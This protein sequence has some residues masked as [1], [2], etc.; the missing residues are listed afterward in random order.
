MP[1][2]FSSLACTTTSTGIAA[3]GMGTGAEEGTAAVDKAAAST[4]LYAA[5]GMGGGGGEAGGVVKKKAYSKKLDF[6]VPSSEKASRVW[7][8]LDTESQ[9]VARTEPKAAPP[10]SP[11]VGGGGKDS[12]FFVT[13]SPFK[14]QGD[15]LEDFF[16]S[17]TGA[18][19]SENRS[20]G[21]SESSFSGSSRA[22][23]PG[24]ETAA[25]VSPR[26]AQ[27]E[28]IPDHHQKWE[29]EFDGGG[30][31]GGGR[32]AAAVCRALDG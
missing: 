4:A 31:G 8:S 22:G 1:S 16:A 10:A 24:G 15:G 11:A 12:H 27:K 13:Q 26:G 6:A 30:G 17:S 32:A 3:P 23:R 5:A 9:R 25:D 21:Y 20:I 14:Y 29:E 28:L 7:L 19:N 2:F 18:S